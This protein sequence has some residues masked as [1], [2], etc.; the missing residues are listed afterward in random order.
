MYTPEETVVYE[1]FVRECFN[2]KYKGKSLTG[3]LKLHVVAYFTI[4]QSLPKKK[5]QH[6]LMNLI[7]PVKKPD[8]DNLGKIVSDALNKVAYHDDSAIVD[9]HVEKFYSDEPRVEVTLIGEIGEISE[10]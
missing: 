9:A 8:W 7:R 10:E 3:E 4:G 1:E 2:E 5:Q 6:M